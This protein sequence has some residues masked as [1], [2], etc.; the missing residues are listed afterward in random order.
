MVWLGKVFLKADFGTELFWTDRK[1]GGRLYHLF[2]L[3]IYD[4]PHL[5]EGCKAI[6]LCILFAS[7]KIGWVK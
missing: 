4:M 7:F 1:E 3:G 5:Q 2:H 6:T